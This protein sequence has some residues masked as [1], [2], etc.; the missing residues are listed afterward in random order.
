MQRANENSRERTALRVG[1]VSTTLFALAT[2]LWFALEIMPANLGFDDTDSPSVMLAFLRA[3]AGIYV[4]SGLTLL[5]MSLSL[6]GSVLGVAEAFASRIGSLSLKATSAMGLME[7]TSLLT[8]MTDTTD[9]SGPSAVTRRSRSIRP[10]A[11]TGTTRPP[12][13]STACKTA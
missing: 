4:Y 12:P 5:F 10:A 9:T 1:G 3:H 7:P 13:C 2:V 11:S 6:T 8:V